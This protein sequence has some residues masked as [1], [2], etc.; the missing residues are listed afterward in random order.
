[1]SDPGNSAKNHDQWLRKVSLTV[2]SDSEIIDL[3]E[4]RVQFEVNQS[5]FETPNHAKIRI[6]NLAAETASKIKKEF[7]QVTLQAGYQ[8]GAYGVIF[9]G[10]I[11][12]VR[13]GRTSQTD[14]YVD[15]FAADGDESYNFGVSAR[16]I[17]AGTSPEDQVKMIAQD[18]GAKTGTV[19]FDTG[20]QDNI[21]GKVAYGMSRSYLRNMA[22]TGKSSWSIQNGKIVITPL[23]GYTE[24]EVIVLNSNT[25]MV[26]L[27]EQT[28][29]GIKVTCLLNPKIEIGVQVQI[30]Q[31]SVQRA[32]VSL[33]PTEVNQFEDAFPPV[34]NDGFYTIIVAEH[35]GDTRDNEY[36]SVL[37]CLSVNK[38][39][40]P[41]Q[42]V[43]VAG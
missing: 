36:Y 34:T 14:T 25:G 33:N 27:P 15:I 31:A 11:K 39:V 17:A 22:R 6:F 32:A 3:S 8:H 9:D 35:R 29:E 41:G 37:T 20:L 4:L 38:T 2:A 10:T 5:D 24:G 42:S 18:M 28:E 40:A 23:T 30:D 7:T 21:R 43:K 13:I 12:Q 26:G 16:S 1:M 19:I